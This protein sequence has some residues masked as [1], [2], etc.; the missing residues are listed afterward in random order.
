M[1]H[2]SAYSSCINDE[3]L[4]GKASNKRVKLQQLKLT[5]TNLIATLSPTLQ[6]AAALTQQ[7]GASSWLTTLPLEEFVFA[8]RKGAFRDALALRYGW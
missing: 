7:K 4:I 3:Q 5:A 1:Q 8:I 6:Q 2:L